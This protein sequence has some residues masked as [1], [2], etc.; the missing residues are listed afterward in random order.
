MAGFFFGI[1]ITLPTQH[2]SVCLT[3]GQ[4]RVDYLNIVN[5]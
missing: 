2:L 3:P 5:F 4:M 1:N